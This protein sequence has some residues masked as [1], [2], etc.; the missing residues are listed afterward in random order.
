M[1]QNTGVLQQSTG[2]PVI[3]LIPNPIPMTNSLENPISTL[4][5]E[6]PTRSEENR[7]ISAQGQL[8][9][10]VTISPTF[11][12]NLFCMKVFCVAFLLLQFIFVI[13]GGK[14]ISA[15]AAR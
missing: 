9:N 13:F 4:S 6:N 10:Q 3:I 12:S 2:Q 7:E 15:K 5:K 14:N 1:Q 8:D 11:Y